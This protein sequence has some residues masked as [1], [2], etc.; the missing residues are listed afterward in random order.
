MP[1]AGIYQRKQ[2]SRKTRKYAFDQESDQ[3]KKKK[4]GK[5]AL[6]QESDQGKKEI[7]ITVKKKK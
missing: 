5:H 4:E 6:D 7:T 2:E 1:E 3:E